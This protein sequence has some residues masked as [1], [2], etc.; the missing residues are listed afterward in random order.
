MT[1][2][3]KKPTIDEEIKINNAQKINKICE[4]WI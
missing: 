4:N 3:K 2:V 1:Y